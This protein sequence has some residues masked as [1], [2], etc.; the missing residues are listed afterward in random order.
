MIGKIV[1]SRPVYDENGHIVARLVVRQYPDGYR[2]AEVFEPLGTKPAER[3]PN[4]RG[5]T[6]LRPTEGG[7][8]DEPRGI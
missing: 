4:A 7:G 6:G 1:S 8:E 5:S 2:S 3:R